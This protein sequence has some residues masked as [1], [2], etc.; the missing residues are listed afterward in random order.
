MNNSNNDAMDGMSV[1][2]EG[3]RIRSNPDPIVQERDYPNGSRNG[4]QNS[5]IMLA[6]EETIAVPNV[7]AWPNQFMRTAGPAQAAPLA[8]DI[9][10]SLLRF[11]WTIL[12]IFLLVSAPTITF[13][14]IQITPQYQ[15][16][17]KVRVRPIIPRLVFQTDENGRIPFY[18]SFVNTQVSVM[19]SSTV[20]TRV[21]DEQKVKD[22]QWYKNPKKSLMQR[23]R[24]NTN[25]P[26]ERLKDALSVHPRKQTE[27]IDVDFIDFS[28]EDAKLILNTILRQYIQ[29]VGEM[30]N[31][32]EEALYR[33]LLEEYK[34][35]ETYISGREKVVADIC[36]TLGTETPEE[37][38]SSRRLRL[39]ETKN[40][41]SD[42]RQNIAVLEWQKRTLTDDSNDVVFVQDSEMQQRY[43]EDMEWRTRDVDVRTLRHQIANSGLMPKHPDRVRM[44]KNLEFAEE[45]LRLREAQL[46]EQWHNQLQDAPGVPT[47]ITQWRS[48][49][50]NV[51][52]ES[53]ANI[54]GD[55]P[56]YGEEFASVEYQ[57]AQA[58]LEE[59]L[60]SE[61][62][63]KQQEEFDELLETVQL[64]NKEKNDLRHQRDLFETVRERQTQKDMERN[65]RNVIASVDV[66]TKAF[67]P[68]QPHSDRRMVFS[69]MMLVM[70]LGLGGGMAFLRA[71]RNQIV[72]ALKDMPYPMQVPFLGH[73]PVTHVK[74]SQR[75]ST[76]KSPY[77]TKRSESS[78]VES[79]RLVRT[80]LLSR[81]N[82]QGNAVVL[83][84]SAV[85]GTGKSHF[86]MTLGE[87]F[88]RAGKKVLMIDADLRKR[89]LTQRFNLF[90]KS[91]FMESLCSRS[92]DKRNIFPT[93]TFGLSIMPAGGRS[94]NGSVF[95]E[96][97]NGAF[98][99]CM[100][101]LREHYDIILLDSSPILPV[102]DATILSGQVDGTIM[103]ERELVSRR[104]SQIEA[105]TRLV[106]SGG[107]LLGT[108]FV[109]SGDH[110]GYGYNYG[111]V[112]GTY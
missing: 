61:K 88:A 60:V 58:K 50:I 69:A 82:R 79:V 33:Q 105:L 71:S 109:G 46:D 18:D 80:A 24:G 25:P 83:V 92:A 52:V 76:K 75:R 110:K 5:D 7:R 31:E 4:K 6:C 30:S 12:I 16:R 3:E 49:S 1:N 96:T 84:T 78:L 23:I 53:M 66:L 39:D 90:D 101:Q 57:L 34:S 43:E 40:R 70:G 89:T 112:S 106:S 9:I 65:V 102:A 97:A 111:N 10:S 54:H 15:A 41:L 95:E 42:L 104:G 86:T 93:D 45:L 72:Y 59:Q 81:L 14:W 56:D 28:A 19:R 13:I 21:L 8:S 68:S 99:A 64:L 98:K 107:S 108:V 55:S 77:G 94:D 27:I 29:F 36:K 20:L 26:L 73:V 22:T 67:A 32:N 38:V 63:K 85:P 2:P 44:A 37:L 62:V 100:A 87:S 17:A 47:T 11:K 35:L 48:Q 91:G 51:L 103:V 74:R